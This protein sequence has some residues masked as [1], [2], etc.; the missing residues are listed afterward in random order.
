MTAVRKIQPMASSPPFGGGCESAIVRDRDADG[1]VV[2][3]HGRGE[4]ARMA[5]SC[6]VRPEPGDLVLVAAAEGTLWVIALL[7][8]ATA[9]PLAI[10]ARGD[11]SIR[12]DRGRLSLGAEEVRVEAAARMH[13]ATGEI[14]VE[15]ERGHSLIGTLAH[16]GREVSTHVARLRLV[17]EMAETVIGMIVT[18]ARQ[19]LRVVEGS[20][21]LRSGDIDHRATG[22]LSLQGDTAFLTGETV[23]KVDA[24]QIHM[25]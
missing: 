17:G 19:S 1:L 10:E 3:R 18:R 9:R 15:A 24:E 5:A 14:T 12:A 21:Q 11:L 4:P 7:E 22:S 25:G 20:D 2:Q 6:L 23:V 13:L 8:T 16:V